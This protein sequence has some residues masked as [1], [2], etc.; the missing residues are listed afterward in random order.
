[1][2]WSTIEIEGILEELLVSSS[3]SVQKADPNKETFIVTALF[4]KS[5]IL[6]RFKS[7]L[8]GACL[9]KL[10]PYDLQNYLQ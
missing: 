3:I 4:E 9:Q 8:K 6:S 10:A 7:I 5:Q 1:M 2:S